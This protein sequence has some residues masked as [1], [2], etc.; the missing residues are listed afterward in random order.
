VDGLERLQ[1][2]GQAVEQA[3]FGHGAA[4]GCWERFD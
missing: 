1:L 4:I 2:A 3:Q